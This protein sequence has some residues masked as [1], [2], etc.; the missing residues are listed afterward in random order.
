MRR[1]FALETDS[2]G[3]VR[4]FDGTVAF[5]RLG[6]EQVEGMQGVCIRN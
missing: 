6:W 4:A 5:G 1:D 2:R 3:Q